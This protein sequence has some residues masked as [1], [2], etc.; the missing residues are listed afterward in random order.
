MRYDNLVMLTVRMEPKL[1]ER[2]EKSARAKGLDVSNFV[3]YTLIQSMDAEV[4]AKKK[5][6]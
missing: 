5:S 4:A 3:R 6:E 2:I 1:K